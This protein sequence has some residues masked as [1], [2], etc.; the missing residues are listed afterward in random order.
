MNIELIDITLIKPYE[1]NAKRHTQKQITQVANSI[2]EFGF[3]Q[4]LVVDKENLLII[5]H[6]RLESAKYLG[7]A[8]VPVLRMENLNE[9][10]VRTLR[11]LDNKLNESQWD[12]KLAIEDLKLLSP[13]FF[14]LTGFDRGIFEVEEDNFDAEAEYDKID[15]P[16][17]SQGQIWALGRHRLACGDSTDRGV[18]EKLMNGEKAQLIFTDPPYNVNY[19][20]TVRYVKGRI[21]KKNKPYEVFS[22]DKTPEDFSEFIRKVFANAFEFTTESAT[23]YCWHAS[24]TAREFD[25]GIKNAGWHISQTIYWLK[26]NC[27]FQMGLDYL[28]ITEP[29]F[30]GWKPKAQRSHFIDKSVKDFKNIIMLETPEFSEM[31]DIIYSNRDKI[32]DYIHPTQK[33]IKLGQRAIKKHSSQNDIVLDFFNGS[34]S[35]MMACEQMGR[36]CFAVE[37]DPKFV[38][39]A[40][41]RW[42]TFTGQEAKVVE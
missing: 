17:A 37:L 15:Q 36:R 39:V 18:V 7:L 10:Q 32:T 30:F 2:K 25:E 22:D 8:N 16:R 31:I 38:D 42:E 6:C 34:G 35:T 28:W 24:K 19:D 40:V 3:T 21:R 41:K 14:G 27:T 26:N 4:P 13:E 12:L 1:K 9:E 5:G 29:C 33:P 11:L 20:Y 23:F